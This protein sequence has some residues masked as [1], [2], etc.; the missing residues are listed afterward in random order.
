MN[1]DN[2]RNAYLGVGKM[3]IKWT[4]C[5]LTEISMKLNFGFS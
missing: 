5:E 2:N 1:E 4:G 3:N